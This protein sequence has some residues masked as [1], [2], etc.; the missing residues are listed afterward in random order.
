MIGLLKNRTVQNAGW[1][2]FG[3]FA[4]MLI[5][6]AVSL[7]TAR[8]LGPADYGLIH[9]AAGGV[10]FFLSVCDL[11]LHA[12]LVKELLD[13]PETQGETL[14]SALA[15]RAT[16]AFLS[17]AVLILLVWLFDGNEPLTVAVTA[18]YATSL[19]FQ[20]FDLFSLWFQAGL[21]SKFSAIASLIAYTVAATY[22]LL[23]LARGKN[24]LWFATVASLESICVGILLVVFYRRSGGKRL[25]VCAQTALRLLRRGAP[26]LLPALMVS[27]YGYADKWMLKH[28][29]GQAEVGYYS[30]AVRLCG[31]W[32]F[33]LNAIIDSAGTS[34]M[35]AH[36]DDHARFETYNRRLYA[37]VFYFSTAMSLL[38]CVFARPIVLLLYGQAYLPSVAPLRVLT[39]YTAFSYLG[40]ARNI[41][42]VCE[43]RQAHLKWV[44]CAGALGNVLLNA[45]LIPIWGATG[46]AFASLVTQILTTVIV[47]LLLRGTRRNAALMLEA[48]CLK[49]LRQS[50]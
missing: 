39:W 37:L 40:V 38:L 4:Q 8:Y 44:Y 24:V 36:A 26:F 15:L 32:G 30:T 20:V 29:L 34:I 46:A 31:L 23:L 3:K 17:A 11:G 16:S 21:R 10:T 14:G 41:W 18:L 5:S 7:L 48:V 19:I 49:N 22:R 25:H 1:L 47:P 9:Y 28:M 42:V 13:A 12:I 45:L 43:R 35:Q 6:F 33:A 27:V 2:I 50:R